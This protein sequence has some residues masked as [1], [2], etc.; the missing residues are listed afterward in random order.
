MG[1]IVDR[2][3]GVRLLLFFWEGV[4]KTKLCQ[5]GCGRETLGALIY[6]FM[7]ARCTIHE[8]NMSW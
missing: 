6:L 5:G 2:F 1:Y 7:Q 8:N 3:I 4:S